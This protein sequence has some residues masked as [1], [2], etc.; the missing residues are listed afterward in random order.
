MQNPSQLVWE[1]VVIVSTDRDS[2]HSE[3]SHERGA[4]YHC[5]LWAVAP[6]L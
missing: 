3:V 4:G 1:R 2:L 6:L 5:E